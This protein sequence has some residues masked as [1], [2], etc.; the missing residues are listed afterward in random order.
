M[1]VK[2]ATRAAAAKQ[3]GGKVV[4]LPKPKTTSAPTRDTTP[5]PEATP[6][7]PFDV[8]LRALMEDYGIPTA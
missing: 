1:T 7:P 6:R 8:A 3:D 4:P 5:E 2:A